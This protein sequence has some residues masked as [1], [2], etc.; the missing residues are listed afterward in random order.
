MNAKDSART[1]STVLAE[2]AERQPD[3]M[4]RRRSRCG[5]CP[6]TRSVTGPPGDVPAS[7][8]S[9]S[10]EHAWPS[11]VDRPRSWSCWR[12]GRPGSGRGRHGGRIPSWRTWPGTA[13]RARRAQRAGRGRVARRRRAARSA[14]PYSSGSA[15]NVNWVIGSS[16]R[17]HWVVRWARPNGKKIR[18][19]PTPASA[20]CG[21]SARSPDRSTRSPCTG[22]ARGRVPSRAYSS[23]RSTWPRR[24]RSA[25]PAGAAGQARPGTRPCSAGRDSIC[26]S[27]GQYS[28][29]QVELGPVAGFD[30]SDRPGVEPAFVSVGGEKCI[31]RAAC[32]V[33]RR[34]RK[35]SVSS[36]STIANPR[37]S[38]STPS[39]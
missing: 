3:V 8:A 9:R 34:R 18:S 35:V 22:R 10:V 24:V 38:R 13:G 21:D 14:S 23:V 2:L 15:V 28:C 12:P 32:T 17:S 26:A 11:V 20:S 37:N 39:Q 29:A 25:S 16:P 7:T 19:R 33:G 4:R 31:A 27:P 30:G 1:A 5:C 36:C 6:I